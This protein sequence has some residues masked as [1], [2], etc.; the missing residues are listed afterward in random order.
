[1]LPPIGTA[2][3]IEGALIKSTSSAE[4][5]PN[6]PTEFSLA[7]VQP[8]DAVLVSNAYVDESGGTLENKGIEGT[9]KTQFQNLIAPL[10]HP[11]K[12]DIESQNSKVQVLQRWTGRVVRVAGNRLI[13]IVSDITTPGNPPEEVEIDI[14]DVSKPDSPLVAPGAIFYWAIAY[15]DT[16]GGQRE[17]I[18]MIR[19]ARQPELSRNDINDIFK[20]ADEIANLL[21]SD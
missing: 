16:R 17:R 12:I 3:V 9:P 5:L 6:R 2:S 11:L 18:T 15:R 20:D 1:M 21:E 13:A 7:W 10:V 19:F 14:R 8:W 4:T